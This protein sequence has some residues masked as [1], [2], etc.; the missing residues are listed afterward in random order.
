VALGGLALVLC[1]FLLFGL[2]SWRPT[3]PPRSLRHEAPAPPL[4]PEPR[5]QIAPWHDL[6]AQRAI[7]DNL[8]HTYGWADRPTGRARIP[9]DRAMEILAERGAP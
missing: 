5:L 4:P 2:E 7:E 6:A 3:E 1:A 8:L 9:I